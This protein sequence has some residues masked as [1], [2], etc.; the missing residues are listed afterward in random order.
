MPAWVQDVESAD[1]RKQAQH[2]APALDQAAVE[3]EA[4]VMV[5]ALAAC[6]QVGAPPAAQDLQAT[7]GLVRVLVQLDDDDVDD[8]AGCTPEWRQ[9]GN[10]SNS[11]GSM[12][13]PHVEAAWGSYETPPASPLLRAQHAGG[14]REP[15]LSRAASADSPQ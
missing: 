8:T 15:L 12:G 2:D 13:Q 7:S 14:V 10:S 3:S 5:G 6:G 11:S 9:S 1:C 4:A